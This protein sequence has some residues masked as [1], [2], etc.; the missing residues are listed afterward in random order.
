MRVAAQVF[1]E[2]GLA[3]DTFGLYENDEADLSSS[4]F[5]LLPVPTTRDG[6]TVHCPL[7]GRHILLRDIEQAAGTRKIF[8]CNY[9]PKAE[10]YTDYCKLDSYALRNAVPTAEGA[11]RF[12]IEKTPFTLWQARVLVIG[13]GRVGKLLCERLRGFRCDLTAAVRKPADIA[14]CEAL[15][16]R[17]VSSAAKID[18]TDFDLIFNT[19]DVPLLSSGEHLRGKT[20][21]DLASASGLDE[22]KLSACGASYFKAPGLPGKVAPLSA[23]KILAQT[24]LERIETEGVPLWNK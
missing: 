7:T 2:N 4:D 16:Y 24:V 6:T 17:T 12:A 10:C 9:V 8:C 14:F 23:G 1:R 18:C 19:V 15:G 21:I 3:V 13:F 11:I 22:T 20:V 5:F